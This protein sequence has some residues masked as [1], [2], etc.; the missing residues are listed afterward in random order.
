MTNIN[1]GR[2][3]R[4]HPRGDARVH[5]SLDLGAAVNKTNALPSIRELSTHIVSVVVDACFSYMQ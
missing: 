3:P 5:K 4:E 1:S 2:S